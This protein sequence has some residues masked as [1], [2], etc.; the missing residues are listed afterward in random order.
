VKCQT[1][2]DHEISIYNLSF[3]P[4]YAVSF[5]IQTIGTRLKLRIC[6]KVWQQL[7][8]IFNDLDQKIF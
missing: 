3:I 8:A 5:K 1:E 6:S 2:S 4:K 7:P